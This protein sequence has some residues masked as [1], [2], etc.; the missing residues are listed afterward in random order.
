MVGGKIYLMAKST[1]IDRIT[2]LEKTN[3]TFLHLPT[4]QMQE[5]TWARLRESR[6]PGAIHAT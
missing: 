2:A 3:L 6:A 1:R 5:N 4:T